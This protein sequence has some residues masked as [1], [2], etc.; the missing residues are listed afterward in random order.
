MKIK[1]FIKYLKE[2]IREDDFS[3]LNNKLPANKKNEGRWPDDDY[4]YGD[5]STKDYGDYDDW[6]DDE[7]TPDNARKS[8]NPK[9]EDDD[10]EEYDIY[11]D[12]Q[13]DDVEHLTYLLR[14]MF[15]NSG[16]SDVRAVSY[17]HLRAHET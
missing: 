10:D 2:N 5:D 8:S 1:T 3:H 17:T 13:D 15:R 11:T 16:L 4:E 12:D 6:Y 14:Q 9:F 7:S